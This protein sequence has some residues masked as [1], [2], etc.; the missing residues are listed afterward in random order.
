MSDLWSGWVK[1]DKI[2]TTQKEAVFLAKLWNRALTF[3]LKDAW[4]KVPPLWVAIG[5]TVV[6]G[7]PRALLTWKLRR[8][9]AAAEKSN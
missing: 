4:L 5:A 9:S 6:W 1:S 2:Q 7:L 8:Q 3:I